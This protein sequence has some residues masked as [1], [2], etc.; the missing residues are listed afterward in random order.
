MQDTVEFQSAL[1]RAI[2]IWSQGRNIPLTLATQL[3]EDGYIVADLERRY[4]R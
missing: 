2:A 3:M 4:R 1:G